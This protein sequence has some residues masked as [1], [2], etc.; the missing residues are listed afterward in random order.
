MPYLERTMF[1]FTLLCIMATGCRSSEGK[2]KNVSYESVKGEMATMRKHNIGR[3]SFCV[4]AEMPID[5]HTGRLREVEISEFKWPNRSNKDASRTLTWNKHLEEI[6]KLKKPDG[7]KEIIIQQRVLTL[8]NKW[9]KGVYYYGNSVLDDEGFWDVLID[10]GETGVWLKYN[11]LVSAREEMLQW[12]S[13]VAEAYV[14]VKKDSH[15][16]D[17]SSNFFCL[18][19]GALNVPYKHQES[20]YARF[21]DRSLDLELEIEMNDTHLDEPKDEGLLARTAAAILTRF[22]FGVDIDKIR[23]RDRKVAGLNGEEQ[24]VRMKDKDGTELDFTWRY[25]GKKDSGEYPK[26]VVTMESPDG[27]LEEKLKVW[28]AILDSMKP[29][30]KP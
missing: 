24:V 11:G 15:L 28:D 26:I 18:N 30:Y 5:I 4:P 10:A 16:E 27:K 21:K 9:S 7:I 14:E 29:L 8:P 13:A 2:E 20:S 19:Y 1:I 6:N 25:A 3:F 12:I 23:S 22:S 17:L